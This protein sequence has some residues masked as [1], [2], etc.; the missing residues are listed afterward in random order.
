VTYAEGEITEPSNVTEYVSFE[1]P[2]EEDKDHVLT[3][4]F[5]NKTDS[6]V[7]ENADKTA[8]EKDMLLNIDSIE[9]DDIDLATL[10]M[11]ASKFKCA[12]PENWPEP[13]TTVL[14]NCVNFGFNGTYELK[15]TS[16]F[17]MWLL[18]NL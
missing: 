10:T 11:T 17:Y 6:D 7:V 14:K 1:C 4:T 2:V 15:F 5:D 16:P 8:I 9:I 18:D 12:K 3:V 13:G